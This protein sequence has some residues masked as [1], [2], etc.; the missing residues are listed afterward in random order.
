VN[1]LGG[2]VILAPIFAVHLVNCLN[3]ISMWYVSC[4]TQ[5]YRRPDFL[6]GLGSRKYTGFSI[7]AVQSVIYP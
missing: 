5:N 1:V 6:L 3:N 7:S 2:G 4:V